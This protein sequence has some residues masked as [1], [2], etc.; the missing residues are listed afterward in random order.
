[1]LSKMTL[2]PRSP[3]LV[4]VPQDLDVEARA[5]RGELVSLFERHLASDPMVA[6]RLAHVRA[7]YGVTDLCQDLRS[8]AR[9]ASEHAAVFH[10][11]ASFW[12]TLPADTHALAAELEAVAHA[13]DGEELKQ[14][15]IALH[16]AWA[17]FEPAYAQVTALGR[18]LFPG[19]EAAGV[20][21]ALE[22]IVGL[23][24][25]A[26]RRS[27]AKLRA[28]GVPEPP[29]SRRSEH[30]AGRSP[31]IL[32]DLDFNAEGPDFAS[33]EST[34]GACVD[35]E[36]AFGSD[37]NLYLGFT[38]IIGEGGVFVATYTVPPVGERIQ[39]TMSLPDRPDP[40]QVRGVVRWVREPRVDDELPP[41]MGVQFVDLSADAS[42]ALASF[43]R[44][45]TPLFYDD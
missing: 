18:E 43:A 44:R 15:R 24:R 29:A 27:S 19:P 7:A 32:A 13:H 37:S 39:L 1:V 10:D 20:F 42:R 40:I 31:D 38:E 22:A 3:E 25:T 17:A 36:L 30:P 41:G 34:T 8:L 5:R 9:L 35:V 21:P 11:D 33:P 26:R 12:P 23:H 2:L 6:R 14:T 4:T 16:R 28:A 45:R